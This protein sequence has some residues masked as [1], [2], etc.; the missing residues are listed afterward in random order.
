MWILRGAEGAWERDGLPG[1]ESKRLPFHEKK[2]LSPPVSGNEKKNVQAEPP[3]EM[4]ARI[5][6]TFHILYRTFPAAEGG[7]SE[8]EGKM[9][10]SGP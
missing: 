3:A 8:E 5:C 4:G 6:E 1:F 10:H 9:P 7:P 2:F